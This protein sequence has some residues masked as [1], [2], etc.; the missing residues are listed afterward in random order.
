MQNDKSIA[1]KGGFWTSVSTII[2]VLTQFIRLMVLTRFLE[3]SDFGVV[4]IIN[5]II[6]LCLTFTDLGFSSAL[7]YKKD[8]SQKEFSTLFWLQLIIFCILYLVLCGISPLIANFYDEEYLTTLIPIAALSILFQAFGKLYD[9]VLQKQYQ[10]KI[11]AFRNISSS[12]VSLC[13]GIILACKGTGV[14]SLVLSTLLYSIILNSWNFFTGININKI[15]FYCNPKK[16]ITLLKIGVFQTGSR[17]LDFM[18]NK[19]D[20]IIIGKLLGVESLG[21]YDLAKNLVNSLVDL[22][23]TIVSKVSLPILSNSNDDPEI[24]RYRFLIM[25]KVVAYIT[26]PIC[27][28]IAIFSKETLWIVYGS[29]YVDASIIVI[30]FAFIS[31][32][33]SICSFYDMLGI[34]K[35]R[36]DLNFYNTIVRI[37]I[38]TPIIVV[39]SNISINAVAYGQLLATILQSIA[40]WFI[41]VNNTYPISFKYY[42]SHFSKWLYIQLGCFILMKIIM[43]KPLYEYFSVINIVINA[44]VYILLTVFVIVIFMRPDIN[45]FKNLLKR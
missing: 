16:V 30:L 32:F 10:F 1:L 23:R 42:F 27:I 28:G 31:I 34:A 29:E 7:M 9:T 24:V 45:Y 13:V 25:T 39:V 33:N 36:T 17:I 43:L 40:F 26:I 18:S 21:I 8:I 22:V 11:I 44:V 19:I 4:S 15:V 20:V 6:G 37:L 41:V 38:T 14:Y 5:T 35:G 2:T 12:I 3:K